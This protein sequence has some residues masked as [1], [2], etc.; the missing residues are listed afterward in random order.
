MGYTGGKGQAPTYDTVCGGDGHTEAL[1]IEY[2][3]DRVTYEALLGQFFRGH[4]PWDG[5]GEA[6]Y[7]SAIW[8]HDEAQRDAAWAALRRAKVQPGVV[9]VD[10]AKAWHDAEDYH[11]L[12]FTEAKRKVDE[13]KREHQREAAEKERKRK[14][15]PEAK[16]EESGDDQGPG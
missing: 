4:V 13:A 15:S 1:R 6:Q 2:D 12:W 3:P 5:R 11:Q 9:L 10:A 8:W 14:A 7:R 16:K